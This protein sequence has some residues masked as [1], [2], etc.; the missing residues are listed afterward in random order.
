MTSLFLPS[1]PAQ[2]AVAGK[3]RGKLMQKEARKA[4]TSENV[5]PRGELEGVFAGDSDE[6]DE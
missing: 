2:A 3:Y 5:L 6:G 1:P 4:H